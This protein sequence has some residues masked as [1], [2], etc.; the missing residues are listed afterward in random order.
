MIIEGIFPIG[1]ETK[2]KTPI[3]PKAELEN[4]M[5][6]NKWDSKKMDPEVQPNAWS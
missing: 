3:K 2:I 6:F 1:K 4:I 5:Y